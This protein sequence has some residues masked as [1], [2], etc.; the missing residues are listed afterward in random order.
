MKLKILTAAFI[1]SILVFWAVKTGHRVE[2][3]KRGEIS[4]KVGIYNVGSGKIEVV[5]KIVKSEDEWKNDLTAEQ[6]YIAR[7]KGTERPF[8][9]KY[10]DTKEKGVY[11]CSSC[12]TDL[13]VSDAKFDSGTGWPSFREPVA[14]KNIRYEED[15]TLFARRTEI[16]C[17]RC[18]AHLGHV[19]DDGPAPAY[20]R[21]CI[22]SI[23]LDFVKSH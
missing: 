19:F 4:V 18:Y 1:C 11:R 7:K 5:D 21:Y 14:R 12:G 2:D 20:K 9:G 13:F 10:N 16:L 22:N 15:N 8:S 6:Y 3:A 23:A 17:A